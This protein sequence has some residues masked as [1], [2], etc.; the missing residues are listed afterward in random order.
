V[1]CDFCK[2]NDAVI[3]SSLILNG[4]QKMSGICQECFDRMHPSE[5]GSNLM[6]SVFKMISDSINQVIGGET[7]ED[8]GECINC[9]NSVESIRIKSEFGCP[10]CFDYIDTPPHK[11]EPVLGSRLDELKHRLS[12]AI[13]A[14]RYEDAAK[15]RDEIKELEEQGA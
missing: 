1:K 10:K 5:A 9:G 13:E 11:V 4:E 6:S 2:K 7:G 15:I 3:K 12:K 8:G 14:E